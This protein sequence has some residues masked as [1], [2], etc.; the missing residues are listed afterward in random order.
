MTCEAQASSKAYSLAGLNLVDTTSVVADLVADLQ[1]EMTLFV[2]GPYEGR[3]LS[4]YRNGQLMY[5]WTTTE[6]LSYEELSAMPQ[7]RRTLT[8]PGSYQEQ[9]MAVRRLVLDTFFTF[10]T[11]QNS[12]PAELQIPE[13]STPLVTVREINS[14]LRAHSAHT[15]GKVYCLNQQR[16]RVMQVFHAKQPRGDSIKVAGSNGHWI[17]PAAIWVE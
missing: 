7:Q 14:A 1:R 13:G 6:Q 4:L 12:S 9:H 8:Y 16:D 3:Y 2:L 5:Y 17:T 10:A 11:E 15:G